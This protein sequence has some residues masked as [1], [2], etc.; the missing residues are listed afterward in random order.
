LTNFKD[1]KNN[2]CDLTDKADVICKKIHK[3]SRFDLKVLQIKTAAADNIY[4]PKEPKTKL[5][6]IEDTS[7]FS[8]KNKSNKTFNFKNNVNLFIF[9]N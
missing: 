7:S 6:Y 1:L 9:I 2:S 8:I 4:L 3:Q 5:F